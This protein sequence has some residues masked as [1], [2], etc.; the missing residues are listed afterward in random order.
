MVTLSDRA[1][2]LL[3]RI[4]QEQS[5]PE[6]PRLVYEAEQFAITVSPS[7]PEDEVLYHGDEP[8]LRVAPEA[9]DALAGCTITAEET[10]DGPRFTI[11]REQPPDG[12]G[13][14]TGP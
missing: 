7:E 9:V 1:G 5:L 10:V 13:P 4:Q 2:A 14:E 12:Q 8:V 11:V 3:Q 6:P